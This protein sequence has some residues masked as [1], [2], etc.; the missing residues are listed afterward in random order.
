MKN[1]DGIQQVLKIL[2]NVYDDIIVIDP[3]SKR[4]LFDKD[5]NKVNDTY[6]CEAPGNIDSSSNCAGIRA[7]NE[8]KSVMKIHYKDNELVLTTAIPVEIDD[9]KYV[10]EGSKKLDENILVDG[11]DMSNIRAAEEYVRKLNNNALKDRG[12][13]VFNSRFDRERLPVDVELM[14]EKKTYMKIALLEVLFSEENINKSMR[15]SNVL[16]IVTLVLMALDDKTDW[17][18]LIEEDEIMI[19][20]KGE[21]E[22]V[23]EEKYSEIIRSLQENSEK[24]EGTNFKLGTLVDYNPLTDLNY[25]TDKL[26]EYVI[27]NIRKIK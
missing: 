16:N 4:V 11:I 27:R 25:D 18:S 3:V 15:D 19:V 6:Y 7:Y 26:I 12:N 2:R 5:C 20:I 22:N 21:D 24:Y 17:I 13:R 14:Q 1:I 23:C 10:I 8:K 9:K